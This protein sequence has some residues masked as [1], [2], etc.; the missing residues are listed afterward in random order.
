MELLHKQT[1]ILEEWRGQHALPLSDV[2]KVLQAWNTLVQKLQLREEM[3]YTLVRNGQV[4]GWHAILLVNGRVF[5]EA[6][7]YT[8]KEA[9]V[10]ILRNMYLNGV[11]TLSSAQDPN[12]A[13]LGP[14]ALPREPEHIQDSTS[15]LLLPS[16]F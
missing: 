7:S 10:C 6:S 16:C 15:L 13:T 9:K 14:E 2:S 11:Q 8:K 5:G 1:K 4:S 3:K 12:I